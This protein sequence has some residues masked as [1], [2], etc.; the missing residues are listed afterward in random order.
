MY[1]VGTGSTGAGMTLVTLGLTYFA[2][3]MLSALAYR[4]PPANHAE[5]IMSKLQKPAAEES[6]QKPVKVG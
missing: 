4:L 6:K 5:V 3:M 1:L 2:T